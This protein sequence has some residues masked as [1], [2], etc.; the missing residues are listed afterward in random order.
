MI[1]VRKAKAEEEAAKKRSREENKGDDTAV[2]QEFNQLASL[3]GQNS[4]SDAGG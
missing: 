2:T 4:S 1:K 3:L